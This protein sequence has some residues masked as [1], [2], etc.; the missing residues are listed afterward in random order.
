[1][2][3]RGGHPARISVIV[4]CRNERAHIRSF[5][6]GLLGQQLPSATECEVLIADGMSDDGTREI[7]AEYAPRFQNG[8]MA[9]LRV[10]DNP[11]RHVS[12]GLNRAIADAS[13]EVIVRMDVHSDYAPDYIAQSVEALAAS[14]A[15]NAGGPALTRSKGY[16]QTAI[17]LAYGS[18]FG[19]GGAL[20]HDGGYEGWVDTVTYGCWRKET[21]TR[22]G[23]FDE[24]LVRNQ[25]DE[26]NLR[27]HRAGGR[28][29]QTPKIRSWYKPRAS[30]KALFRQYFQY[31]Y[32]KVR[33][34]RKHRI[35]AS[36][37]HLVPGLFAASLAVFGVLAAASFAVPVLTPARWIL[38]S[39]VG[40]YLAASVAATL[41]VC[42]P[43]PERW[44]YA[45]AMP[46]VFA[47]YHLSYGFGF[48]R[49]LFDATSGR[50]T[51]KA[52]EALSR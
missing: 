48:L 45:P 41:A 18:R 47:T 51:S 13:G 35:P 39:I 40:L 22:L 42:A 37:R 38:G 49:G 33:V 29:W 9:G 12:P 50:G 24:D 25:D 34:L 23:M 17:S 20:F 43:L 32:W 3:Q 30:L 52:F 5:L 7:L 6:D 11:R 14:G 8:P 44:K 2:G 28:V 10:I 36:V 26:L 15:W 1:M 21:L 19:C 27:I 4:P 16:V 46:A 31:G